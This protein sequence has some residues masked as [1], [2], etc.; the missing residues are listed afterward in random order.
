MNE[1]T[2]KL[3][4][5]YHGIIIDNRSKISMTGI[6]DV[7]SFDNNTVIL[8]TVMGELT[9]KGE[10]LKVSNFT[11]ETGDLLIE[12]ELFAMAYTGEASKKSR[13]SRLFS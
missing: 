11:A 13:L 12:G 7:L 1:K 2:N 5:R 6:S 4:N 9:I 10:G 3:S 8:N